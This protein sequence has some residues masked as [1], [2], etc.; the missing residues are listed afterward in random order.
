M[1]LQVKRNEAEDSKGGM[2]LQVKRDEN[3]LAEEAKKK[4][5]EGMPEFNPE[6]EFDVYKQPE[7]LNKTTEIKS[8]MSED[9]FNVVI[10]PPEKINPIT[11]TIIKVV[12]CVVIALSGFIVFKTFIYPD[13]VDLTADAKASEEELSAKYHINFKRDEGMDKFIPQWTKDA[14]ITVNSGKK[15]N[16]VYIDGKYSGIHFSDRRWT[17]YGLNIGLGETEIA[18][19]ITYKYDNCMVIL[20]DA[21][22]GTSTADYYY[23]KAANTCLVVTISDTT[24][25]IVALTYFTDL[26]KVTE[27]L[28][29]LD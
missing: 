2:K 18:G 17:I 5:M 8:Y 3:D 13:P 29:G 26:A 16:T 10:N 25:R 4:E 23:N 6:L 21:L 14:T 15:L 24:N 9:D 19:K 12:I 7:S 1:A 20:N 22:G 11:G 27:A 28:G